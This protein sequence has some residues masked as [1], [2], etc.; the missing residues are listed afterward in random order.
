MHAKTET[1]A[2]KFLSLL[3]HSTPSC[4][5]FEI[6]KKNPKIPRKSRWGYL[7]FSKKIREN[8]L[9]DQVEGYNKD[10]KFVTFEGTPQLQVE[11][12]QKI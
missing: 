3:Y 8:T 7:K 9:Q 2:A 11:W 5:V 6:K 4:G 10:K 1:N 12:Y